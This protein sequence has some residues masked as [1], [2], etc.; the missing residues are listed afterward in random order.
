MNLQTEI[1][2]KCNLACIECPHRLMKRKQTI[3][4]DNVFDVIFNKYI[5]N[6][7]NEEE[8]LGYPP[9]IIFHKDGETLLHPN[10]RDYMLRISAHR[11]NYRYNLYTNGLLLTEDFI[12]FLSTLPNDIWLFISFHFYNYDGKRNNYDKLENL[13]FKIL[14]SQNP[15]DNIKFVFTS[16]VT[17]FITKDD[18]NIWGQIWYNKV[19]EGRLTIGINDHINPWTGLIKEENCVTFDACPYADFGHLFI[20]VTGN[21]IPCCMILEEDVILG[22]VMV[23]SPEDIYKRLDNF[24]SKLRKREFTGICRKCIGKHD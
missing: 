12:D 3:M 18:L 17:R 8:R 14:N 10:L 22:N 11:P 7:K 20:G 21:V 24:Y 6:L 9:T 2:S 1:S 15:Y 5:L 23:D 19:P 4:D 16:H 13:M